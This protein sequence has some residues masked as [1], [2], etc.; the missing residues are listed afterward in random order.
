MGWKSSKEISRKEA[1]K[2]LMNH[3]M[4]ASNQELEDMINNTFGDDTN[5]PYFGYNVNVFDQVDPKDDSDEF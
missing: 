1:I 3:I 4:E 2:T 5:K